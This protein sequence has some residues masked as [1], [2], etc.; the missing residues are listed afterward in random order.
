MNQTGFGHVAGNKF[1]FNT[2]DVN[3]TKNKSAKYEGVVWPA[4]NTPIEYFKSDQSWS[5]S[6][7]K[8][9]PMSINN[10]HINETWLNDGKEWGFS[11]IPGIE[12]HDGILYPYTFNE[13]SPNG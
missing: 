11:N 2:M 12:F 13:G 7:D 3:D 5:I 4:Q 8:D 1:G 10:T 9:L 6:F